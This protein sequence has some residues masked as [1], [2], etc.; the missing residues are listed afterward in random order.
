VLRF[1]IDESDLV[2]PEGQD[3]EQVFPESQDEALTAVEGLELLDQNYRKENGTYVWRYRFTG[4]TF[5][6]FPLPP[7]LISMGPQTFSSEKMVLEIQGSRPTQT[8]PDA[9]PMQAPIPW[10]KWFGW[11]LLASLLLLAFWRFKD[12]LKPPFPKQ[13]EPITQRPEASPRDWLRNQLR[14]LTYQLEPLEDL[15]DGPDRWSALVKEFLQREKGKPAKAWTSTDMIAGLANSAERD[16]F[17]TLLRQCELYQFSPAFR[18][19]THAKRL[20][21]EWISQAERLFL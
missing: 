16:A 13:P 17:L 21:L 9:G 18:K 8:M 10:L 2:R 11:V 6:T 4:Y 3:E 19:E 15:A 12:R 1:E 5:G 20:T 14:L 7:V